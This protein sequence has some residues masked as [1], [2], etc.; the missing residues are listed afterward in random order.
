MTFDIV[1]SMITKTWKNTPQFRQVGEIENILIM[2]QHIWF[3]TNLNAVNHI[4]L[5]HYPLL[6]VYS[7]ISTIDLVQPK[8]STFSTR[9]LI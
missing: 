3:D 8:T 1:K 7:N 9:A 2:K 4:L 6:P 5:S